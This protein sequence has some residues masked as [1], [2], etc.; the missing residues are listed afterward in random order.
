MIGSD[1]EYFDTLLGENNN[2]LSSESVISILSTLCTDSGVRF[3]RLTPICIKS[4][5]EE[6]Q[7]NILCNYMSKETWLKNCYAIQNGSFQNI[8]DMEAVPLSKYVVM[9]M[10]HKDA[11]DQINKDTDTG[12]TPE[13]YEQLPSP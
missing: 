4:L 7:E 3:G 11:M 2:S 12:F 8:S 13:N 5:Y 9:C 10:I 1:L 6:L